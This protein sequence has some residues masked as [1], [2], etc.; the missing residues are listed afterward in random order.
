MH[1]VARHSGE[2]KQTPPP[3]PLL[4]EV[5]G[6][7]LHHLSSSRPR[8]LDNDVMRPGMVPVR[9]FLDASRGH[10][11]RLRRHQ[12]PL[13]LRYLDELGPV[14]PPRPGARQSHRC[15]LQ[16][17]AWT[18]CAAAEILRDVGRRMSLSCCICDGFLS[19]RAVSREPLSDPT[20]R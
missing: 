17:Q 8:H 11:E 10:R 15:H 1:S 13:E 4:F 16:H 2:D 19:R 9:C 7:R 14:V 12:G 5:Q 3:S 18:S 6:A 20:S